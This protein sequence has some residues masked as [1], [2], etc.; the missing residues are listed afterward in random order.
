VDEKVIAF[1]ESG[2]RAWVFVSQMDP[3]VYEAAKT[4]WFKSQP[5]HEGIHGLFTGPFQDGKSQ[6]FVGSACTLEILD[7]KG[8]LVKRLPIFWGPGSKFQIVDAPDGSS[9]LIMAQWPNG[10][11][12]PAIVNSK[13][14]AQAGSGFNG[15]PP[16]HTF[17]NGW[18]AQNHGHFFYVDLY[19][20]GK[21]EVVCDQNGSWNRVTVYSVAGAPMYN[22]QFGPGAIGPAANL[23]DMD[24]AD[25]N[26][27]GKLEVVVGTS[28]GLVVALDGKM[29]KLWA[30]RPPS[31]P[32]VLKAM[33]KTLVVGCEDGTVVTMDAAG[34]VTRLGKVNGRATTIEAVRANARPVGPL[35]VI[36]TAGGEVAGFAVP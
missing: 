33:G 36:G 8:Q 9:N 15:V 13:T 20:D 5:G 18:T 25:L 6:C 21:K 4:Y 26:G 14:M 12:Y 17:V 34:A 28:E 29:N 32:T 2:Q 31:P 22:A 19:G 35:V 27:D 11:D 7:E 23:R 1:D 30:T 24:V 3:A 10:Y 16:R